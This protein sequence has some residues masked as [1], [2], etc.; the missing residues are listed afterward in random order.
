MEKT[1]RVTGRAKVMARPDTTRIRISL[2]GVFPDYSETLRE[3]AEMKKE[4]DEMVKGLGFED[5]ALKTTFF[6]VETNY[7]R[8][9]DNNGNWRDKF[10]GYRYRHQM[11]L[12]FPID[13]VML[14]KVLMGLA[15]SPARPQFRIE[16]VIVDSES[17]RN[18]V[19]TKAVKDSRAKA[20]VL[21]MAGGVELG[22]LLDINYSWGTVEFVSSTRNTLTLMDCGCSMVDE[23][24]TEM[25]PDDIEV[26][27]DV[28]IMWALK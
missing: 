12:D 3:S 26:E 1:I 17:I 10:A 8:Y 27:D 18:E 20:E 15:K 6:N 16:Y 11:K 9:K 28:T 21:A 2:E 5:K 7:E 13:N 19:L 4:L 24:M 25:E 23:Y 22:E 14:G